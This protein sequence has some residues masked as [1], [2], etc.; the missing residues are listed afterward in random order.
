M[1]ATLDV[2]LLNFEGGGLIRPHRG[3]YNF[4]RLERLLS[5]IVDQ[6]PMLLPMMEAKEYGLWGEHGLFGA[7]NTL[8]DLFGIAY[9]GRLGVHERGL[10][11]PA[12]F[13]DPNRVRLDYWGGDDPT[14]PEDRRNT[15][16]IHLRGSEQPLRIVLA[17]WDYASGD[18]RLEQ[19]KL[20][21]HHG[22][23]EM[24]TL[25]AGDLNS[26]ASRPELD[27]RDWDLCPHGLR[28]RAGW[29]PDGPAG[30]W[31]A[32]T[33]AID[34]LIGRWVPQDDERAEGSDFFAVCEIAHDLGLPGDKSFECTVNN[35]DGVGGGFLV[36]WLLIN[37]AWWRKH[38]MAAGQ[39]AVHVPADPGAEGWDSDHRLVTTSFH[40]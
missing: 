20:I 2:A 32:D 6:P 5:P 19:A 29:Q 7:A 18:R 17:H 4:R 25:L 37:R 26:T 33:R 24:P 40:L 27:R 39:Y 31:R 14:V 21:G 16:I 9:E 36:D 1:N 34:H 15:A 10:Y 30:P 13:Y 23:S 12:L 38:P 35:G 28:S 22:H 8:T 3:I 11:G